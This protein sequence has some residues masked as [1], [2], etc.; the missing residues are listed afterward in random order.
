MNKGIDRRDF[1]KLPGLDGVVFASRLAG[2]AHAAQ[3]RP[4]SGNQY[5]EFFFVQVVGGARS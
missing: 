4:V 2:W 3:K 5:D 1:L